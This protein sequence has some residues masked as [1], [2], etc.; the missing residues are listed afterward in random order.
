MN[1]FLCV[2]DLAY[3]T[4]NGT[5]TV[6]VAVGRPRQKGEGEYLCP[7]QIAGLDDSEVQHAYGID[8]FQALILALDGIRS[9]LEKSGKTFTWAGG[10]KGEDGFPRF[11]PLSFGMEFSRH[12]DEIIESEITFFAGVTE[13]MHER[14]KGTKRGLPGTKE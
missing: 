5:V 6:K 1:E 7:F 4:S 12:L 11:V 10:E 3:E 2:R 14:Q 9:N 8:C 13:R